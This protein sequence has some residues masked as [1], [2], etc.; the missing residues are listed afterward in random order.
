MPGNAD[1]LVAI[2]V[3]GAPHGVKGAVRVNTALE[4]PMQLQN[5]K[6]LQ[7]ENGGSL[8]LRSL[9]P[10]KG[11][12]VVAEFET[13]STRDAAAGLTNRTLYVPREAFPETGKDE[14]YHADLIGLEAFDEGGKPLG[15]VSMV[16]NFGAGDILE[17]GSGK[18]ALMILFSKAFVPEVDV[19]KRKLIVSKTALEDRND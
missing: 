4:N 11:A 17:I 8:K 10:D 14:F 2:G 9:R 15:M 6:E 19:Q 18:D 5:Y 16:H 7:L 13:V 3:I 1:R 12:M